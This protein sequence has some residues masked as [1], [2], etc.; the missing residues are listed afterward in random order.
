MGSFWLGPGTGL[1]G[2]Q[3]RDG[4]TPT[5]TPAPTPAPKPTPTP[6]TGP[7]EPVDFSGGTMPAGA[8]P[9]RGPVG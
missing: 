8:V 4:A 3:R 7:I 2:R 1:A 9:T 6:A 5:P